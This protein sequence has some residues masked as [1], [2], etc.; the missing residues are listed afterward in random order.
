MKY[1]DLSDRERW[2]AITAGVKAGYTSLDEIEAV[3]N[4]LAEEEENSNNHKFGD[5][6][7][8]E[9]PSDWDFDW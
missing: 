9:E 4:K 6:G 7:D 3:Y 8:T 2:A 5:G 1:Q